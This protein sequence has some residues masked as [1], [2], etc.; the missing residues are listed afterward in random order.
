MCL[1]NLYVPTQS[2]QNHVLVG[3]TTVWSSAFSIYEDMMVF[4]N[5]FVGGRWLAG[6]PVFFG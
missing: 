2:Y 4:V 6:F 3:S 5:Y 1:L